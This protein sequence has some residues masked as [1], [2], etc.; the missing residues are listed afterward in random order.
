MSING[1]ILIDKIRITF[2][3][4]LLS[5]IG[6]S[7]K[8]YIETTRETLEKYYP[9]NAYSVSKSRGE[10]KITLTPTRFKPSHSFAYTDVN[11]EMPNEKWLLNLFLELGFTNRRF[12]ETARIVWFHL[13]KNVIVNNPVSWYKKF[14]SCYPCARGYKPAF[15]YS[16]EDNSTLRIATQKHNKEKE[17]INGDRMIIFYDKVQE[18]RDKA[19]LDRI[20]L[21][22]PLTDEEISIL[23]A[24]GGCYNRRFRELYLDNL[25]LLRCEQQ[26]KYREKI[27][28]LAWFL[29][30][31]T[32]N[33]LNVNTLIDLLEEES[34][35]EKLNSFY[36][37]QLQ[38][39][40]FYNEP[41]IKEVKPLNS[42]QRSFFELVQ[43]ADIT[44]LKLI[45][46]ACG[47]VDK[48]EKNLKRFFKHNA[49][50]LYTELYQK[51]CG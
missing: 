19:N 32:N 39:I 1:N 26:Y 6:F 48:F 7:E 9:E 20:T 42:Y 45:Y 11:I 5:E 38:E 47:L 46:K 14:L 44:E 16:S 12:S 25:N 37:Q 21:K 27:E 28:P 43:R 13:T 2:P 51:F 15:V 17:D 18:L 8:D 35:Y 30:G 41:N 49:D 4:D 33:V 10:I 3:A 29:N 23:E 36:T 31:N 50:D 34:L 24:C 22:E 40:I